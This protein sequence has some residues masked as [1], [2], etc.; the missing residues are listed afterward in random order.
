MIVPDHHDR[1]PLC[2][3]LE[4]RFRAKAP[5]NRKEMAME[6]FCFLVASSPCN[7]LQFVHGRLFLST[8]TGGVQAVKHLILG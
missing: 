7:Y 5:H 2:H 6:A 8:L 1:C 3:L 4:T